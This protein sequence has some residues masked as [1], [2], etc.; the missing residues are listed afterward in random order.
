MTC[1]KNN[2]ILKKK[3][4]KKK[5]NVANLKKGKHYLKIMEAYPR[6]I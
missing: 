2:Q 5:K 3:K 1:K 6:S 4:K